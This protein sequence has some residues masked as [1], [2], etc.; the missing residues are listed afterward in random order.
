MKR[1]PWPPNANDRPQ[2]RAALLAADRTELR[3][4]LSDSI[5]SWES[6]A[7]DRERIGAFAPL[8]LTFAEEP[9]R[10]IGN[11]AQGLTVLGRDKLASSIADLLS[12][13]DP[14][15]SLQATTLAI[16]LAGHVGCRRGA[17]AITT[18]LTKPIRGSFIQRRDFAE[19]IAFFVRMH[20]TSNEAR[21]V[22]YALR[23]ANLSVPSAMLTLLAKAAADPNVDIIADLKTLVPDV[24]VERVGI[25]ATAD[26]LSVGALRRFWAIIL[27]DVLGAQ[28]AFKFAL[29]AHR[30]GLPSVR[31]ALL[32]YRLDATMIGK[33]ARLVDKLT[34]ATW[35]VDISDVPLKIRNT[36]GAVA[37]LD[38]LIKQT[39]VTRNLAA[40]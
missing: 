15:V 1:R 27:V 21:I 16:E 7:D 38:R 34:R 37:V 29:Y 3:I 11:W 19:A 13:W 30:R 10:Q 20:G 6:S 25:R 26:S 28:A 23:D 14:G 33:Q 24:V 12:A 39:S 2:S 5:M 17:N 22:A 32:L 8:V 18:L 31:V 9:A 35:N 36:P 4:W 40:T